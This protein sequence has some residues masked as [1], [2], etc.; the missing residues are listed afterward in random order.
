LLGLHPGP[1]VSTSAAAELAGIT[2][3]QAQRHLDA[4][5]NVHLLTEIARSR[6]Q[7]HDLLRD[8]AI[9]QVVTGELASDRDAAIRRM[10][11]WYLHTAYAASRILHPHAP[12]RPIESPFPDCHPLPFGSRDDALNWCDL[13]YANLIATVPYAAEHGQ[14]DLGAQL[15]PAMGAF[16][17]LRSRW[18][19]VVALNAISLANAEYLN[20]RRL[21]F[22]STLDIA[23]AYFLMGRF[24]EA[25]THYHRMLDIATDA[26]DRWGEGGARHG[27][28]LVLKGLNRFEEAADELQRAVMIYRE[29]SDQRGESLVLSTIGDILRQQRRF[30]DAL[31]HQQ[32]ALVILRRTNNKLNEAT[33]RRSMGEVYSDSGQLDNAIEQL[34]LAA[35]IYR[36]L[37]DRF[38]AA[39][40]LKRLGDTL[41]TAGRRQDAIHAWQEAIGL[42]DELNAPQATEIRA[43]IST[44]S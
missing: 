22:W 24:T 32:Q 44:M 1:N 34:R 9:E 31:D 19:D 23:D 17:F 20:D 27:L 18:M 8:Y 12:E 6:Y 13:E 37:D 10:L 21:E 4:L 29:M 26:G 40:T 42:F 14:H 30:S 16:L 38:E 35:E 2:T 28:G 15:P 33:C 3:T 25:L 36:E 39:T 43:H 5:T 7:F 41:D 11:A